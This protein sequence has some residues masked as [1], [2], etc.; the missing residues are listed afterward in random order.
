VNEADETGRRSI[1]VLPSDEG[2]THD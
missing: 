1:T 2:R